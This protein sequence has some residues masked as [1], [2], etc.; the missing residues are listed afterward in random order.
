MF[1]TKLDLD[2]MQATKFCVPGLPSC[3]V[4]N[5]LDEAVASGAGT[6]ATW[7]TRGW[8]PARWKLSV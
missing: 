7:T 8:G 1:Y 2:S 5:I 3:P 4:C 6:D